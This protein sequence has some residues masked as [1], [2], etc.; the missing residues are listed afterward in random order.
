MVRRAGK[1]DRR[2]TL[3]AIA[4]EENGDPTDGQ[5]Q[6]VASVWAAKMDQNQ[7]ERFVS[8][9]TLA[10]AVRGYTIRYRTD[11]DPTW[12]IE[13]EH[14]DFWHIEGVAEGEGRRRE[15]VLLCSRYDPNDR[16]YE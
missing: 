7:V 3:Q 5:W 6:D 14:N 11:V 9:Q 16:R 2:I 15:T 12:R 10:E 1:L 13:D 8:D 4:R